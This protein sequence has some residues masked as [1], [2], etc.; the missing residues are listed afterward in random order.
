M[1]IKQNAST[2]VNESLIASGM[3]YSAREVYKQVNGH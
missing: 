2:A 1:L 3:N